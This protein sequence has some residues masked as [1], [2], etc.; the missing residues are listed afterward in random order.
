MP[1]DEQHGDPSIGQGPFDLGEPVIPG[2]DP[3]VVPDREQ[4]FRLQDSQVLDE[5]VLPALVA[6]AVADE[7]LTLRHY[8]NCSPQ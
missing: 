8:K 4:P 7:D 5:P 3:A 1:R 2:R 6:V